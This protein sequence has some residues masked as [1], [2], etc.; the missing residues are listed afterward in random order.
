MKLQLH[1][2]L[3]LSAAVLFSSDAATRKL[4][5]LVKEQ[6]L[7]LKYHNGNLLKGDYTFNILMYG[8]FTSV[9]KS[10]LLDFIESL[11]PLNPPPPPSVSSWWAGTDAYSYGH[12][13]KPTNT[14]VTFGLLFE[15]Y[16]LSPSEK[17]LNSTALFDLEKNISGGK[18]SVGIVLTSS[19]VVVDGFCSSKCGTHGFLK[20]DKSD[21][22]YVWVGNSAKQCPG[23]CA[24][25]FHKPVYGPQTPPLLPPNG[26]VGIDG[27]IINLATLFAGT[28]TNPYGNGYFQGPK[29]G[30]L[31]AV[32]ACAGVFGKGSYPGYPGQVLV[33]KSTGASYNAQGINGRKY[34][35]PAMWDPKTYK[36]ATLV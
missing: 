7:V 25:P 5:A 4:T 22:P 21:V 33:D 11:S 30:G 19:E 36:C 35:L 27:M 20:K 14:N 31:E 8:N 26:D 29:G 23:H 15:M 3:L 34:L 12:K 9:Q 13:A 6:P 1:F 2:F 24:W 28:V 17:H 10:I 18:K 32:S 16:G